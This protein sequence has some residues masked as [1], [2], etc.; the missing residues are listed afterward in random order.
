[1]LFP[2]LRALR[3]KQETVSAF[4]GYDRNVRIK[5]G[6]FRDM[7]NL[8]GDHYPV[9]AVRG[10]RRMVIDM[11]KADGEITGIVNTSRKGLLHTQGGKIYLHG[12]VLADMELGDKP[13]QFVMMGQNL[14]ILPDMKYINL[15]NP[16]DFGPI[17]HAVD[18][19]EGT[20]TF[21][22]CDVEGN[23]YS[24]ATVSDTAPASPADK[25]MWIDTSLGEKALKQ[26]SKSLGEWVTITRTYVK[27]SGLNY[28]TDGQWFRQY[29][30]VT[31]QGISVSG[32]VHLNGKAIL[33]TS[34]NSRRIVI[35][36]LIDKKL[37]QSCTAE[38]PILIE[39]KV[40]IMDFVIEAGNRL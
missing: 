4:R 32:A 20:V 16:Q 26:Y 14:I 21:E 11:A 10:Q 31:I 34:N 15:E 2:K 22:P 30:G 5:E 12:K 39:R 33:Q 25:T 8:T 27:I 24:D 40:P 1:M 29:D 17:G 35:E 37:E 23:V 3:T 18:V 28:G 36:G 7:R 9:M 38:S 19:L 6:A 13:K